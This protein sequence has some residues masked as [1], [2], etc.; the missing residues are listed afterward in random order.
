M[1]KKTLVAID[2][3]AFGQVVF[4]K[5]L[6]LAK[7][8]NGQL[9]LLNVLSSQEEGYP[10]TQPG[11]Y[12]QEAAQCYLA[13]WE[14]FK[15]RGLELLQARATQAIEMGVS[16]EITQSLGNPG[17]SICDLAQTWKADLI[18]L[19]CHNGSDLGELILGSVSNYVNHNSHC[20]VLTIRASMEKPSS[21]ESKPMVMQHS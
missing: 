10:K 2:N 9:M 3:S 21:I 19:G 17:Q 8:L 20:S 13:E 4:E 14:A 16:T 7:A 1:F 6:T 11:R 5:A 15:A 18:V 12:G